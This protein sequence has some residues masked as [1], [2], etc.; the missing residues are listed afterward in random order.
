MHTPAL[1]PYPLFFENIYLAFIFIV[2]HITVHHSKSVVA[3][4]KKCIGKN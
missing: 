3:K 1:L 2:V 4:Q